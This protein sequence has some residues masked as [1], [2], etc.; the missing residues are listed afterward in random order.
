M[1]E[2]DFCRR[3]MSYSMTSKAGMTRGV[4]MTVLSNT[5]IIGHRLERI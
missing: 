3:S 1:L 4:G 5:N 2:S